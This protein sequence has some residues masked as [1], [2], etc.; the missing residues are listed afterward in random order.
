M[1]R[2]KSRR[3]SVTDLPSWLSPPAPEARDGR[4]VRPLYR[5][6]DDLD[7]EARKRRSGGT[8][9][10]LAYNRRRAEEAFA[11]DGLTAEERERKRMKDKRKRDRRMAGNR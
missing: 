5:P 7:E 10:L 2:P 9:A 6:E 4:L 11:R 8:E 1:P 3:Y